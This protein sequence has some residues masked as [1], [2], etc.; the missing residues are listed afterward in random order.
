MM[1]QIQNITDEGTLENF[2]STDNWNYVGDWYCICS[3]DDRTYT[4]PKE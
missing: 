3:L 1:H 4:I 2:D